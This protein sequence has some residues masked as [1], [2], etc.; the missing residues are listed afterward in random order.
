VALL[1]GSFALAAGFA[2]YRP[3]A[4]RFYDERYSFANVAA[5]LRPEERGPANAFY[6]SLSYLP[7]AVVLALSEGLSRGTG[8][9]A[10]SIYDPAAGDGWSATAYLLARWV[11][12]LYGAL[13]VAAAYRLGSRLWEPRVGLLGAF[14]FAVQP[15]LVQAAAIFKPDGLV[16]LLTLV[17]F[18]ASLRA[19]EE[20]RLRRYLAVGAGV[21][22]TV[23]AKYTGVGAALPVTFGSL[24]WG[25][26]DRRRWALLVAAG[27]TSVVTFVVLNPHIATILRYIP[28]LFRIA[29]GKS[30]AEGGSHLLV[31][32]HELRF[33]LRHHGVV[34]LTLVALG[35][36][37]LAW[38][39]A[40]RGAGRDPRRRTEA[41]MVLGFVAG[42]SL[43]YAAVIEAFRGQNYLPASAVTSL[44]AAWAAWALWDR[45]RGR[46]RWL[47]RPLLAGLLGT[48]ALAPLAARPLAWVY[49]Q[50]VPT[51]WEQ[52][53]VLL[54]AELPPVE[55]RL[56]IW[57]RR[58]HRL[59][60]RSARHQM[61][62][63]A[64]E[65]L[66]AVPVEELALADA[67][68]FPAA[69]VD[70]PQAGRY[71]ELLATGARG[72]RRVD[73][74]FG[75]RRGEPLLLVLAGWRERGDGEE[76]PLT[77][78]GAGFETVLAGGPVG[79]GE[80]LSFG[81]VLER[82]RGR[83][84]PTAVVVEGERLPLF[85]TRSRRGE[86]ELATPRLRVPA[87]TAGLTV[88]F[89]PPGLLTAPPV[90]T[91]HR[92]TLTTGGVP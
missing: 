32:V 31:L 4:G 18:C 80:A 91:A 59:E 48:V 21:G 83:P 35:I 86:D 20:P 24:S 2:T 16:A 42:Y 81:V 47:G 5:V 3:D 13:A 55:R 87:G 64:V 37:G 72:A 45:L 78:T 85:L 23:A 25:L 44:V 52:A 66:A 73:P 38:R 40:G 30:E 17:V 41:V 76:L 50:V 8:V 10:L 79:V 65:S 14:F 60:P 67:V 69:R 29:A 51:T 89:D 19:V 77:A 15:A 36:A 62:T 1:A 71:L 12:A 70:G 26:R 39:A 74:R 49:G 92:W 75:Q 57:E 27:A 88:T 7:Q 68:L 46:W 6:P 54:A 22:L 61:P 33:L 58:D 9:A 43:L 63:R 53:A 34:V 84:R 90:M 56:V 28:R 11:C 82:P